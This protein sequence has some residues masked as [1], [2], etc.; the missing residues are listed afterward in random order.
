MR[1]GFSIY[2]FIA[3]ENLATVAPSRIRWSAVMLN[4]IESI[5][6]QVWAL[7]W[8]PTYFGTLTAFPIAIMAACGLKIVGTKYLPPMFPTLLTEKVA[9]LKSS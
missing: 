6:S 8:W 5:G 9:W 7:P 1:F 3:Y 4:E 2:F